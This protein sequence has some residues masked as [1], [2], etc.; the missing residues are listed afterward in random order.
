[1]TGLSIAEM[2]EHITSRLP[3]HVDASADRVVLYWISEFGFSFDHVA[4]ELKSI[5]WAIGNSIEHR[6]GRIRVDIVRRDLS[7]SVRES[8]GDCTLRA[9]KQAGPFAES[10]IA[11]EQTERLIA[12]MIWTHKGREN[13]ISIALLA[14]S[15]GRSER[16]IKGIV[17]QLVVTHRMRIGALRG[18]TAGYFIV[19]DAA[20]LEAAV[21]PYRS[22]IFSMW[23]RLRVLLGAHQLRELYG[24]L[25]IDEGE[26]A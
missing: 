10:K 7:A 17:E 1:M 23:R 6:D 15:T 2:A 3:V 4:R 16:E 14:K 20:D 21:G 22:Q 19:M 8:S 13:P 12:A 5:G 26:K 11:P 9:P 18:K 25:A 24:Q